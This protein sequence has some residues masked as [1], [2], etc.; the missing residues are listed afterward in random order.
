MTEGFDVQSPDGVDRWA[1]WPAE[2]QADL[3]T[4]STI[5]KESGIT[6]AR[7][8]PAP[9]PDRPRLGGPCR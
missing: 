4:M 6:P 7:Q 8:S 3:V 1:N 2:D 5:T 9:R